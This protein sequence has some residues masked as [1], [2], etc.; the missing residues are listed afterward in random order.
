MTMANVSR[1]LPASMTWTARANPVCAVR[2]PVPLL[3]SV[4]AL[5]YR[6]WPKLTCASTAKRDPPAHCKAAYPTTS[7]S[8]HSARF[9]TRLNG[10]YRPSIVSAAR[11]G[12]VRAS[13]R[14]GFQPNSRTVRTMRGPRRTRWGTRNARKIS[15]SIRTTTRAPRTPT[16]IR[17]TPSMTS[18]VLPGVGPERGHPS[19]RAPHAPRGG[20]PRISV[21]SAG[22]LVVLIDDGVV[23]PEHGDMQDRVGE[24]DVQVWLGR[25]L[26]LVVAG[27]P[28]SVDE[29]RFLDRQERPRV[30]QERLEIILG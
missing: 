21:R 27:V 3:T 1:P 11:S 24:R 23:P 13:R 28:L 26:V 17:T 2:V 6:S 16:T 8:I 15:S 7:P 22:G 5:K 12:S 29:I 19:T 25:A 20:P 18:T 30:E 9:S 10:P 4:A 14:H